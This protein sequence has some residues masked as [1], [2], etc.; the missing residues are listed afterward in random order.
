MSNRGVGGEPGGKGDPTRWLEE[1]VP[2][3]ESPSAVGSQKMRGDAKVIGGASGI[4]ANVQGVQGAGEL[5][6][7][8]SHEDGSEA[9]FQ[10]GQASRDVAVLL[11][12]YEE[13]VIGGTVQYLL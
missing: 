9:T 7:L 8:I 3:A 2:S 6:V 11:R 12:K 4:A 5:P 10:I 1:M 13:E